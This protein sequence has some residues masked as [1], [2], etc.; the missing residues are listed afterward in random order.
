ML[1]IEKHEKVGSTIIGVLSVDKDMLSIMELLVS[2]EIEWNHC[3]QDD[4]SKDLQS[5]IRFNSTEHFLSIL[6]VLS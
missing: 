4:T 5:Y 2:L 1:P 3:C 6:S